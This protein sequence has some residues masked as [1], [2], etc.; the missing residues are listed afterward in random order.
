MTMIATAAPELRF[1][2]VV[3]IAV[4]EVELPTGGACIIGAGPGTAAPPFGLW[5]VRNACETRWLCGMTVGL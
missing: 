4:L 2:T 5:P 3:V 1:C